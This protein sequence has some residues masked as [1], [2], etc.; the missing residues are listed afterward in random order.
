MVSTVQLRRKHRSAGRER[1]FPH[2]HAGLHRAVT[3]DAKWWLSRKRRPNRR[4][5]GGQSTAQADLPRPRPGGV[6]AGHCD[7]PAWGGQGGQQC[8]SPR[9]GAGAT[10]CPP[11]PRSH[12][13]CHSPQGSQRPRPDARVPLRARPP[14]RPASQQDARFQSH[15]EDEASPRLASPQ[16]P[17]NDRPVTKGSR[18][19]WR[20]RPWPRSWARPAL[21]HRPD[22][23]NAEAA[24][25][26]LKR[27]RRQTR[28][29]GNSRR[30]WPRG[31]SRPQSP[32]GR[33]A[34]GPPPHPGPAAPQ[35]RSPSEAR[36][37]SSP[38]PHVSS[39]RQNGRKTERRA[40]EPE[41]GLHWVGGV[42]PRP[43]RGCSRRRGVRSG[44]APTG[45]SPAAPTT[46]LGIQA[47]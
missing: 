45:T 30:F 27:T 25:Q 1:T 2:I 14:A 10:Q 28:T 4:Q 9:A 17:R 13:Q 12:Q 6:T 36:T 32:Q 41:P 44:S 8:P 31:A 47:R 34:W 7:F 23:T 35:Q 29:I 5:Q 20:C 15:Q 40:E 22:A 19:E 42:D 26:K 39:A 43:A 3:G 46:H 16:H 18:T 38:H 21:P 33:S 24:S 11:P 37:F